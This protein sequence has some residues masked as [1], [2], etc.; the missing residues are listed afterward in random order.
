MLPVTL[1]EARLTT[2]TVPVDVD[3][4]LKSATGSRE[5]GALRLSTVGPHLV[6]WERRG[7][8]QQRRTAYPRCQQ[9]SEQR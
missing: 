9:A 1:K 2:E 8:T 4:V 5:A 7:L 6:G 3:P